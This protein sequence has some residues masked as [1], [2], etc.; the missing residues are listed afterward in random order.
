MRR[1]DLMLAGLVG[2]AA[3]TTPHVALAKS[4][5]AT[6]TAGIN[7]RAFGAVGDGQTLDSPAINKAIEYAAGRGGGT[8]YVPAGTYACYSIRLKSNIAL[9]LDPGAVR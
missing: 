2:P 9:A 4:S 7:V 6:A 5:T 1:R 8:V 3:L